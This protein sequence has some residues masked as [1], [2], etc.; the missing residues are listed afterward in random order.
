VSDRLDINSCLEFVLYRPVS[1]TCFGLGF[2][3]FTACICLLCQ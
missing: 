2:G 3:C 1:T